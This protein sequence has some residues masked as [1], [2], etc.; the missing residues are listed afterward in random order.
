VSRT[1]LPSHLVHQPAEVKHN[2]ELFDQ[3]CWLAEA[4]A[5]PVVGKALMREAAASAAEALT[6]EAKL[7]L[8]EL[9]SE[10]AL[11]D[12]DDPGVVDEV[13]RSIEQ[14]VPP[15]NEEE[16]GRFARDVAQMLMSNWVET[17][18]QALSNGSYLVLSDQMLPLDL[19]ILVKQFF[20]RLVTG[21]SEPFTE[22]GIGALALEESEAREIMKTLRHKLFSE[23]GLIELPFELVVMGAPQGPLFAMTRGIFEDWLAKFGI[24]PQ[25]R[26]QP[27]EEPV[28]A[29]AEW[30][31]PASVT[32]RARRAEEKLTAHLS[33]EGYARLIEQAGR[34]DTYLYN[35]AGRD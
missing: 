20:S 4:V 9:L 11:N 28:Y 21:A 19:T 24:T 7:A 34:K 17:L 32:H 3:L 16:W 10:P 8:E 33:S 31:V 15:P 29:H 14:V 12:I 35:L 2:A 22:N 13:R 25:R 18:R 23:P 26:E 27:I 30:G 1:P 5:Y 6:G